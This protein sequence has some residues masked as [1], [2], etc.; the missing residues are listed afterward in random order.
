[1]VDRPVEVVGGVGDVLS[2]GIGSDVREGAS[3]TPGD[4]ERRRGCTNNPR[5]SSKV[6]WCREPPG[7]VGDRAL[8]PSDG[9]RVMTFR[10]PL[11]KSRVPQPFRLPF[12]IVGAHVNSLW[13][14]HHQTKKR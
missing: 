11:R 12:D 4:P 3:S 5:E 8:V 6:S 1:M 9:Q 10:P 7:V 13:Q 14:M 2:V